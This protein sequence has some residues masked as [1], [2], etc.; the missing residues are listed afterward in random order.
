MIQRP[1]KPSLKSLTDCL[2]YINALDKYTEQLENYFKLYEENAVA[3]VSKN[4][5]EQLKKI[6]YAPSL[7]LAEHLLSI[8]ETANSPDIKLK[9]LEMLKEEVFSRKAFLLWKE[10]DNC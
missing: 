2:N 6:K 7:F 8:L 4:T 1:A 5:A 10:S 9:A 3:K